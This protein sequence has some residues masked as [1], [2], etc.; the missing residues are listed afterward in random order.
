M[1]RKLNIKD[2]IGFL[3]KTPEQAVFDWKQDFSFAKDEAKKA[4]IIKDIA[5]IANGTYF[6]DG[7]IFYG[8]NPNAPNPIIGVS[9]DID[10]AILQQ[11]V[12]GK[13]DPPIEFL[14]YEIMRDDK[15]VIVI[16]IARS[17]KRPHIISTD[18]GGLKQGQLLIRKGSSTRGILRSDLFECFYD[19]KISPYFQA[20][21]HNYQIDVNALK[22]QIDLIRI[23]Q[24][25][26]DRI[27]RD[28]NRTLGF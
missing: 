13:V 8:V 28:I 9:S 17:L 23:L 22:A 21:L 25:D 20:V 6:S 24:D 2:V 26:E 1:I 14:K 5:A 16:H 15:K 27:D 18:I 11:F 4:E 3:K 7:Y 10:D 19:L 12:N